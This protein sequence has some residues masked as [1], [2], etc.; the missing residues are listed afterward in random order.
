MEYAMLPIVSF[1]YLST[2]WNQWGYGASS[3]ENKL[4]LIY[5]GYL[6]HL[7]WN[8]IDHPNER[9]I[10]WDTWVKFFKMACNQM[11]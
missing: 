5:F 8:E 1:C 6:L 10:C 3:V 11:I 4:W 9:R 7:N 2:Y